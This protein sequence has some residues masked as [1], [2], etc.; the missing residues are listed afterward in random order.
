MYEVE[1]GYCGGA[2]ATANYDQVQTGNTRHA[3]SIRV[4]YDPKKITYDQL[5]D[6]FFEAHDPTQ[7]NRQGEDIGT[8]YRSAIFFANDAQKK[9]AEAKIK[10]LTELR[11]YKH[12]IVTKLEPLTAFYPAENFH[13]DFV[14][15]NPFQPYVQAHAIPKACNVRISHPEWV[16]PEP[17]KPDAD[18]EAAAN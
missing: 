8:E 1:S 3:E 18:A 6:V 11:V 10:K 14:S 16:K 5:L 2:R 4:N 15:K 13:Q 12:R 7:F 17:G 9:Q